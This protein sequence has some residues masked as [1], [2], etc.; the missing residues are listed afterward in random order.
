M[1]LLGIFIWCILT[2]YESRLLQLT[3]TKMEKELLKKLI[4]EMHIHKNT[5]NKKSYC[6]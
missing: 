4:K 1:C 6:N 5:N 2:T 3:K